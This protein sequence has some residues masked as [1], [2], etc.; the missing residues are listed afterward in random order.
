M[1]SDY[2]VPDADKLDRR[3]TR[4]KWWLVPMQIIML[5]LNLV[6]FALCIWV[7]FDLDFRR[8]VWDMDWYTFWYCTYVNMVASIFAAA[9]CIC[10]LYGLFYDRT[11]IIAFV[12]IMTIIVGLLQFVGATV[13]LIYGVE[14]SS[15]LTTELNEYLIKLVYDWDNEPKSAAVLKQIMEYVGC[16]GS[17]GVEDYINNGKPVPVE[18]RDMVTGN[19]YANGC[20]QE[21]AWYIEPWAASIAGVNMG[22]IIFDMVDFAILHKLRRVINVYYDNFGDY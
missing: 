1:G 17:N 9:S 7:R 11:G 8:W 19:E 6:V 16:C 14:E 12:Q 18:C 21:L 20:K 22:I 4:Y 5:I 10:G 13:I 15:T 2:G 3:I